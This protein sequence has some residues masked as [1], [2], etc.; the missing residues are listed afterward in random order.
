MTGAMY[1]GPGYSTAKPM[2][3]LRG[4]RDS[5][6]VRDIAQWQARVPALR[7]VPVANAGHMID[8]DRPTAVH[9]ARLAF[10]SEITTTVQV[11]CAV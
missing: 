10:L 8:Q 3:V 11:N 9:T 7:Y 4:E 6:R 1:P 5:L 2:L